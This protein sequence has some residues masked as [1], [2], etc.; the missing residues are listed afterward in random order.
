LFILCLTTLISPFSGIVYAGLTFSKLMQ[1]ITL[2]MLTVV[3]CGG[4]YVAIFMTPVTSSGVTGYYDFIKTQ[5]IVINLAMAALSAAVLTQITLPQTPPP[6]SNKNRQIM[7][8]T[9]IAC[10][11]LF[12][13][14]ISLWPL[15]A[16]MIETRQQLSLSKTATAKLERV[17]S[18]STDVAT[19]AVAQHN[20]RVALI[21]MMQ[22]TNQP[23]TPYLA[24]DQSFSTYLA[25]YNACLQSPASTSPSCIAATKAV[26]PAEQPSAYLQR[27]AVLWHVLTTTP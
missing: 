11:A 12:L 3:I 1:T 17:I 24:S 8:N 25:N 15:H 7:R 18:Q 27:F 2:I 14:G 4:E 5:A 13:D 20:L 9:A 22:T 26:T 23:I 16:Y 10:L 19:S 21:Q 6:G